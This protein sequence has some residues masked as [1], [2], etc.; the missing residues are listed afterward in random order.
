MI[1]RY[2][3]GHYPIEDNE[4]IVENI[5]IMQ[6]LKFGVSDLNIKLGLSPI[7]PS[8]ENRPLLSITIDKQIVDHVGTPLVNLNRTYT[9]RL[10]IDD[11]LS[12]QEDELFELLEE[13]AKNFAVEFSKIVNGTRFQMHGKVKRLDKDKW[14]ID[15]EK[16]IDFWNDSI[17][18]IEVDQNGKPLRRE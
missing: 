5:D 15:L 12:P 6:P 3:I 9:Y 17:R 16:V 1:T 13:S 10:D 18:H 8:E 2:R 4:R 7:M 11:N 14:L